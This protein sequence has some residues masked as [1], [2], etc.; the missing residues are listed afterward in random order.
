MRNA[1]TLIE[2]VVVMVLLALL[3]SL[4]VY[5]LS[6]TMD[7]QR[8]SQAIETVEMFDARARR[9]AR[10]SRCTITATIDPRRGE[11]SIDTNREGQ[12]V[13]YRLPSRVTV[14]DLRFGKTSVAGRE[15]RFKINGQG[16]SATYAIQLQRGE[17]TQW[18]VVLGIS[19][20][21]VALKSKG[22]VDAILSL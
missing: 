21:V 3:A 19:G 2:L 13:S 8:M 10:S 17:L 14:S 4:T 20:Q 5:S 1:F 6:G 22:E 16:R 18:L 9:A 12:D 15:S 11:L 7:R